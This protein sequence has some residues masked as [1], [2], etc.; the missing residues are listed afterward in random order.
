MGILPTLQL[1][2]IRHSPQ[3]STG[4]GRLIIGAEPAFAGAVSK[5]TGFVSRISGIDLAFVAVSICRLAVTV[6][7][8]TMAS[9]FGKDL[10]VASQCSHFTAGRR[11]R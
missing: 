4:R 10:A 1:L 11:G 9:S 2:P 3:K 6:G 7:S 8:D 5:T